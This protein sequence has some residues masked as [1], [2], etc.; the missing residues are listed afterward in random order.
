[1]LAYWKEI[2]IYPTCSSIDRLKANSNQAAKNFQKSLTRPIHPSYI[3]KAV[4][5]GS[6]ANAVKAAQ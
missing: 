1:M 3:D 2:S 4:K 6:K 5:E